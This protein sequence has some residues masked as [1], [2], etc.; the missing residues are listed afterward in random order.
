MTTCPFVASV[1]PC[2]A[3]LCTA[4]LQQCSQVQVFMCSFANCKASAMYWHFCWSAHFWW[5]LTLSS[6]FMSQFIINKAMYPELE[7][8]ACFRISIW[9]SIAVRVE[10]SFSKGLKSFLASGES[11]YTGCCVRMLPTVVTGRPSLSSTA[12]SGTAGLAALLVP[13]EASMTSCLHQLQ[14]HQ[15]VHYFSHLQFLFSSFGMAFPVGRQLLHHCSR[16]DDPLDNHFSAATSMVAWKKCS[17]SPIP[18][19]NCTKE[20]LER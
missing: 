14:S 17:F 1:I 19:N 20:A 4:I 5:W 16:I 12:S 18:M 8:F 13:A 15:Q 7:W 3:S 9:L 10:N 2:F 11:K 6:K